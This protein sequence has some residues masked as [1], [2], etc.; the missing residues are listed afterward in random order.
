M[1]IREQREIGKKPKKPRKDGNEGF[2]PSQKRI[3]RMTAKFRAKRL[4][5]M[6]E[7]PVDDDCDAELE[8]EADRACKK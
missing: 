2:R 7:P 4:K 5:E 8:N 3:A 6:A 1:D